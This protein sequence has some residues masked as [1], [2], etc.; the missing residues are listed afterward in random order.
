M[1]LWVLVRPLVPANS[2]IRPVCSPESASRSVS[3]PLDGLKAS[4]INFAP[5]RLLDKPVRV[6]IVVTDQHGDVYRLDQVLLKVTAPNRTLAPAAEIGGAR[7]Q[8]A[9]VATFYQ[10]EGGSNQ[11]REPIGSTAALLMT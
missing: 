10:S 9:E 8:I 6:T 4:R 2:S 3:L 5:T 11:Q 7:G 1:R